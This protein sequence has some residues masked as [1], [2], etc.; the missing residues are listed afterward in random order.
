M[1]STEVCQ[2]KNAAV[3]VFVKSCLLCTYFY[4]VAVSKGDR[5]AQLILERIYIPELQEVK[6]SCWQVVIYIADYKHGA[7]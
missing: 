5:I 7:A 1:S 6:V 4:C 2:I 3:G